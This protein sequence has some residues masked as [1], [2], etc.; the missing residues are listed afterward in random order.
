LGPSGFKELPVFAGNRFKRSL[1][2]L[3]RNERGSTY[4]MIAAA[5]VPLV[6][7]VGMGLDLGRAYLTSS[8]LQSSVDT[9]TL[10]AVRMEQLYPGIGA[11]PGPKTIAIVND[12]LTA[13]MPIGYVG[14]TRLAPTITV[15]RAGDEVT[16]QVEVDGTVPTTL[17]N[18]FGF[19]TMPIGAK[20]KG[21]A[22]K[23]LPTAVEAMLV[24]DNTGSMD[25]NGG[26]VALRDSVKE[27]LKIVY[28]TS[29]TR[30]NF[31][32]GMMPYNVIVN[33]G[34]LLPATMVEQVDGFTN[35]AATDPYG[36]KGCVLADPTLRSL[37]SDIETIDAGT[38]DM[39]KT[40]P[41]ENGMPK[42]KPSIYPPLWVDSFHRQDNR[43]KFSAVAA[44]ADSVA[45]Y[46]P[47]RTALIRQYGDDICVNTGGSNALCSSASTTRIKPSRLPSYAS[48]QN[49]QLYSSTTK[50]SNA[51]DYV[52]RS[53]NYVCPSEAKKVS[54]GYTKTELSNYID[55][56]NQPLFNIG[57]WH[58]QAMTWGYRLLARDDVF[59]RSRPNGVGLRRV[60][61]FMTDGN[62]DSRDD[63]YT[64]TVRTSNFQRDTAYTGYLS[65]ADK[66][67]V[68]NEWPSGTTGTAQARA[69]HRDVMALR[70]AKTCEAMKNEGIEIY[71]ITF[72]IAKDTEGNSTRE[73]FKTCATNRNTHFFETD[74]PADLKIAF[75]T[76]AADLIDLHLE[77]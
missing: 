41:G 2:A 48:W 32:I 51:D 45:N 22:G 26:M 6:G 70:F 10:A 50:P 69:A 59:T 5:I 49:P 4:A 65:Y 15:T 34:R 23:T 7:F 62:F 19:R 68:N 36:W 55:V 21:V 16:V 8:R 39:G 33:V 54:Y 61:I 53:P 71:T 67:V 74:D 75:T 37:S 76:I 18:V 72:A 63:G 14:A 35:K 13:N 17:M 56:Y 27:F 25:G 77:K 44:E 64:S 11:T 58:N 52:S 73:M 1:G 47:M 20:A 46:A 31:A 42:V 28:G 57:T 24:L 38:F 40:L 29:E 30:A 12:F 60:M 3:S 66:L 43:Y 9:A